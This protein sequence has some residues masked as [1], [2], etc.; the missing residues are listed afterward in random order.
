MSSDYVGWSIGL[1]GIV[2]ATIFQIRDRKR[3]AKVKKIQ[4]NI[5]QVHIKAE[6][7]TQHNYFN[8]APQEIKKDLEFI[9]TNT[10]PNIA[11]V[12]IHINNKIQEQEEFPHTEI[13]IFSESKKDEKINI[14]KI[15]AREGLIL[16]PFIVALLLLILMLANNMISYS[17]YD[18]MFFLIVLV[19]L[20]THFVH[21]AIKALKE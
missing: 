15:T 12:P 10:T 11:F 5:Q 17:F 3:E 4:E 13:K 20:I 1:L 14:K 19:Y 6:T 9:K 16:L 2:I 8:N 7:V 21:W 18:F